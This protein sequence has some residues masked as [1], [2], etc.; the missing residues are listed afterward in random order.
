MTISENT[1]VTLNVIMMLVCAASAFLSSCQT[2]NTNATSTS[3]VH[4]LK[5]EVSALRTDVCWIK[6]ALNGPACTK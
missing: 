2:N 1:K 3:E 4:T 6:S 5:E